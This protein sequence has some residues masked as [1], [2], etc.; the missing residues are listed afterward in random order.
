MAA[1]AKE[2][3][4]QI[5]A[6]RKEVLASRA[7]NA[8]GAAIEQYQSDFIAFA[9]KQGVLQFG[10]FKL[11]SGRISPY[12]FNAGLFCCGYSISELAKFYAIA[13][14]RSGFEFDV[15]FG[16]AYKG[17]PLATSVA[18]AYF[19]V[20]CISRLSSIYS[21]FYLSIYLSFAHCLL[22]AYTYISVESNP[23]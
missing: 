13:I 5:N 3:C 16:P 12:F 19:Q 17:I 21:P 2:L 15:I 18:F 22:Y 1:K 11:K 20:T 4:D 14:K 7:A 10:S 9:L 23:L 8:G 6:T